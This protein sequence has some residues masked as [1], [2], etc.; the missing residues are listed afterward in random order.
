MKAMH[1]DTVAV[2]LF[3]FL[4]SG[5]T[6]ERA[7]TEL[8]AFEAQIRATLERMSPGG[9][10]DLERRA[11]RLRD[12]ICR[13]DQALR[14]SDFKLAAEL[15]AEE[16]AIFESVGPPAPA[17]E[18]WFTV[19]RVTP[20]KQLLDLRALL[21]GANRTEWEPG[22]APNGG[23]ASLLGNSRDPGGAPSVS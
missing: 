10:A 5:G 19:L 20:E 4:A 23:P 6:T 7:L 13:K 8:P 21:G 11:S 12:V 15:R 17:G 1:E 16:C 9:H 2:S 14:V 3:T 22:A 18:C